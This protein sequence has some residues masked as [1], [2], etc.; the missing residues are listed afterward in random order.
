LTLNEPTRFP[1]DVNSKEPPVQKH[2]TS[3]AADS[4]KRTESK[5]THF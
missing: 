2:E 4:P 5:L 3:I 1:A